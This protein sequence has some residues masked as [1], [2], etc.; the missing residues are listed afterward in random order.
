MSTK[1][2]IPLWCRKPLELKDHKNCCVCGKAAAYQCG[3][4]KFIHS[5]CQ[6]HE[7]LPDE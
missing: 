2:H 5:L 4:G 7:D 1:R 3:D 6:I